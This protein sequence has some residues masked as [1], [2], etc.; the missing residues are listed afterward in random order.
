MNSTASESSRTEVRPSPRP[1]DEDRHAV[2]VLGAARPRRRRPRGRTRGPPRAGAPPARARG[3]GAAGRAGRAGP[4]PSSRSFSISSRWPRTVSSA[5]S[6]MTFARSAPVKPGVRLGEPVEVDVAGRAAC[7]RACSS[8]MRRRPSWSGCSTVT[9]RSK[10]PGR[11]SAGSRMSGRLVAPMTTRPD[12]TSKPSISTSSWLSV[13]SRSSEPPPPPP[14]PRRRP[15]ASS[16]SMKTIAGATVADPGEQVAHAG[17]ADADERLDEL[18]AARRRRTARPPRR[19]PRARAASCR[20]REGR[21]AARPWAA[22]RRP[23]RSAR[24]RA[25]SRRPPAARRPPRRRRRRRRT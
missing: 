2:D 7:S 21:T 20:S 14:A 6:L 8:R 24:V 16:S 4:P 18:G 22:R 15:A 11:T 3:R 1:R 23:P 17:R 12:W 9:W 13:C 5:A 10:R 19:R 25:G